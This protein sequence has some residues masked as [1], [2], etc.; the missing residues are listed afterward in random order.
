MN[1]FEKI[2]ELLQKEDLTTVEQTLLNSLL[3]NDPE[4]RKLFNVYNKV[5]KAF[6][7]SH[8][9]YDEL[10]DYVLIKNGMEPEEKFDF[11]RTQG[12]ENHLIECPICTKEFKV[13]NEEF[14][15]IQNFVS[16]SINRVPLEKSELTQNRFLKQQFSPWLYPVFAVFI[17]GFLYLS[18]FVISDFTTPN[19]YVH[20]S[21]DDESE[22]YITR[23]RGTDEFQQ[24]I[25]AIENENF[26]EAITYLKKDIDQNPEDETIFYTYYVLGLTQLETAESRFAGLGL[27]PSFDKTKAK[28]TL[29]NFKICTEKNTSG[30][31]PDITYNAYFYSAKANLMIDDIES[32]KKYLQLVIDNKGSKMLEA[33]NMLNELE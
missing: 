33:Q 5:G 29:D 7:V 6:Q 27:F 19:N 4:A 16:S 31:F 30:R 28:Q 18:L 17:L 21:L 10:R 8:I 25:A 11:S 14:S 26:E 12:I 24:S 15:D 23:G 32:A 9:S 22:F 2:I 3:E 20:A 1:N 13:L